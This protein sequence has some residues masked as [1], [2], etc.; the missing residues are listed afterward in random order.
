MKIEVNYLILDISDLN[1]ASSGTNNAK[2]CDLVIGEG[3]VSDMYGVPFLGMV[4]GQYSVSFGDTVAPQV[5]EFT[6]KNGQTGIAPTG[7]PA[8]VTL[9]FSEPIELGPAAKSGS[10]KVTLS[11]LEEGGA[12]AFVADLELKP[13]VVNVENQL[14]KV[15]LN[16]KIES[17]A[18]YTLSLPSGAVADRE[19]N[20]FTGLL[21]R[22][23][24]FKTASKQVVYQHSKPSSGVPLTSLIAVSGGLILVLGI[25][26]LMVWWVRLRMASQKEVQLQPQR[27]SSKLGGVTIAYMDTMGRSPSQR[28]SIGSMR[29]ST[30]Y[31]SSV[32]PEG[33][34][35]PDAFTGA[36]S[37]TTTDFNPFYSQTEKPK[38]KRAGTWA[39]GMVP[40]VTQK[41]DGDW[42]SSSKER[43]EDPYDDVRNQQA[44]DEKRRKREEESRQKL[45]A[46]Q[47]WAYARNMSFAKG[48]PFAKQAST[49][50]AP[51]KM[52]QTSPEPD[53]EAAGP[54]SAGDANRDRV[55][56]DGRRA[57]SRDTGCGRNSTSSSPTAEARS[58]S[59]RSKSG[60]EGMPGQPSSS[61]SGGA[62]RS[63]SRAS[64]VSAADE[65]PE[66]RKQKK[67]VE[68]RFRDLMDSPI[69]VRKKALKEL[70]LEYHPDKNNDQHA[71]QIFQFVN[72]S[73]EWFL[74]E[75]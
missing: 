14:L 67:D 61:P 15:D 44:A 27:S 16:G 21:P 50:S 54:R 38:L 58:S 36:S 22:V 10:L 45:Q 70:M 51:A 18:H 28:S 13:P 68:K 69:D 34:A 71:T 2:R 43:K 35:T 12:L 59:K 3:L 6:P 8:V 32:H 7:M 29:S 48:Q 23:Y 55:P 1:Q 31:V 11:R 57:G 60:A 33:Q 72:G 41:S 66:L 46:K 39:P 65:N 64:T 5:L 47:R 17:G 25:G 20:A 73:K 63:A 37:A 19:Q 52:R 4:F 26:I 56:E 40:T 53:D 24:A 62:T 9:T 49:A 30:S 42:R 74:R 75:A